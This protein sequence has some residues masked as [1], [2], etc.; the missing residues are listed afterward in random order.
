MKRLTLTEPAVSRG[1]WL[2][3]AGRLAPPPERQNKHPAAE[4]NRARAVAE[5]HEVR[6]P[7]RRRPEVRFFLGKTRIDRTTATRTLDEADLL[8]ATWLYAV[9]LGGAS[10]RPLP[11]PTPRSAA[12]VRRTWRGRWSPAAICAEGMQP[13]ERV[14]T[15]PEGITG[16]E[17]NRRESPPS[18]AWARRASTSL[19]GEARYVIRDPA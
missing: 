12:R 17:S 1:N 15:Q 7:R 4:M 8:P 5:Q 13:S 10:G 18:C 19:P 9:A 3:C 6:P 16:H 2:L 14:K 11:W